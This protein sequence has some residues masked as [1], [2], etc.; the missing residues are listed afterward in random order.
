MIDFCFFPE[1]TSNSSSDITDIIYLDLI[2]EKRRQAQVQHNKLDELHTKLF[3]ATRVQNSKL[4]FT[5]A[6][7]VAL[8]LLINLSLDRSPEVRQDAQ[9]VLNVFWKTFPTAFEQLAVPRLL[10]ALQLYNT[11]Y[12]AFKGALYVLYG[13]SSYLE[14]PLLSGSWAGFLLPLWPAII[15]VN[16]V[17][18]PAIALLVNEKLNKNFNKFVTQPIRRR[19]DNFKA[20]ESMLTNLNRFPSLNAKKCRQIEDE[21]EKISLENEES[22]QLLIDSLLTALNEQKL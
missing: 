19:E 14:S 12:D 21:R 6:H 8:E 3:K 17:E 16:W 15:A 7:Q 13:G 22:Y 9:K 2:K 1:E 18:K 10:A 20:I 4:T 5:Q 11:N